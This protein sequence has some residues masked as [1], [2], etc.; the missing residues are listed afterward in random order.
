MQVKNLQINY[1]KNATIKQKIN[2]TCS[3][4]VSRCNTHGPANGID[5]STRANTFLIFTNMKIPISTVL[6]MNWPRVQRL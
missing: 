1:Y 6:H 2:C 4:A 5:H 3:K